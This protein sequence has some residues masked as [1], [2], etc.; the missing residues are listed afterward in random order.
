LR[1]AVWTAVLA[2]ALYAVDRALIGPRPS[3]GWIEVAAVEEL[4]ITVGPVAIPA[5]LPD[6]LSWPPRRVLYKTAGIPGWW[7]GVA[8]AEGDQIGLWIGNGANPAPAAM[9]DAAVCLEARPSRPCPE[10]WTVLST[11]FR[12]DQTVFVLTILSGTEAK[13]IVERLD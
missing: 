7:L 13:R 1:A 10:P 5:Y 9:G 3:T 11:Q 2:T 8:T 12:G 4:P 6:T